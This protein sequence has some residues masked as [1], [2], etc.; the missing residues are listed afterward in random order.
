MDSETV[1]Q[2][3]QLATDHP[4]EAIFVTAW[5]E[6]HCPTTVFGADDCTCVPVVTAVVLGGLHMQPG[7]PRWRLLE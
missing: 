1:D 2:L 3:K 7:P 4:G 6:L 5:H